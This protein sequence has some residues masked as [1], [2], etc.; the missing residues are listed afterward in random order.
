MMSA[1][2]QEKNNNIGEQAARI[3]LAAVFAYILIRACVEFHAIAWGTGIW[4]GE[5]S[6]KWG[7]GFFGFVLFC[8]LT[9]VCT[10]LIMWRPSFF[11]AFPD[12]AVSFREKLGGFRWIIIIMLLVLPVWFLQFTPWG[13]VFSEL[14]FRVTLWSFL[15]FG[16]A[17]FLK[18]DECLL[19]WLSVLT[20]LLLT[21]SVFSMALA[22]INVSDYPFSIGWSEGNRMW[23]YSLIFGRYL[24]DYPL[25]KDV[26]ATTDAGRQLVGGLPFI[27][28]GVTIVMERFWTALT[29]V[30]PYLLLGFAAFRFTAKDKKLW[31]LLGFWTFIFL[32][33]GP[34]H[35]PLVLCAFVVALLWRRPLWISI[36]LII[37]TS[38]LAEESRYT[39]MF[40]PGLWLAM[41]EFSG[42]KLQD[43]HLRAS[44]WWRTIIL[45]LSGAIG[46][47]YGPA[48]WQWLQATWES[49]VNRA[50]A[51]EVF[52]PTP[53]SVAPSVSVASVASSVSAHP[54]LWYRLF[55]NATYGIGIILA[56]LIAVAPTVLL[57]IYLSTTKKWVLSAWQ[58]LAL[59]LPLFA[60]L[61]VGLIV[62]TKIGGG[63]DLHNVDMFLIGIFFAAVI[64]W[65]NGGRQWLR[66]IETS[67]I[68]V[69]GVLVLLLTVP[70]IQPLSALRSYRFAEDISWLVTLTDVTDGKFLEMFPPQDEVDD[71]L[72]TIRHEVSA[73]KSQGEILFMDQRQLLTFGYVD[74]VPLVPEYEKKVLMNAAM[75]ADANYFQMLYTDLASKRFSLIIT[76]PLRAPVKDSSYQFGE[77][78]NAWVQWVVTPVLCYYDEIETYRSA[79]IQLLIPKQGDIDCS[80]E[81][82]VELESQ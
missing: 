48:L 78:N 71:I 35:P 63:G 14:Y 47:F 17:I 30:L 36:P 49:V 38:Y 55:P 56:L 46:G 33:Q 51:P 61:I 5:F 7:F 1:K 62:S 45:G 10:L 9:W 81:L 58:K 25:D 12:R 19:N 20:A 77:E 26:F 82:P 6:L 37:V 79:Q 27:I 57:L 39:W 40:A 22:F 11:G 4:L 74:D 24:Y 13:I 41:L 70:G 65:E 80:S 54:L 21:S 42:A 72:Q 18:S 68:W 67:P 23:D 76:E 66:K 59:A 50:T 75:G 28:P 2:A 44:T 3:L 52:I 32:K 53:P 73:R 34:I 15:V 8:I 29:T 64:A 60:F 69:K 43:G 31:F 16:I